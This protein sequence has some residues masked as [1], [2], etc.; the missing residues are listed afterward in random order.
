MRQVLK[1]QRV[2]FTTP[3]LSCSWSHSANHYGVICTGVIPALP[4][5]TAT[6]SPTPA[7]DGI[8]LAGDTSARIYKG[9]RIYTF[10]RG[11]GNCPAPPDEP[12][13]PAGSKLSAGTITCAVTQDD[14]ACID[15]IMNQGF[16]LSPAGSWSF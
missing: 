3:T 15:P 6:S 9:A 1:S 13:L 2:E 16:V 8:E 11:A 5:T 12:R 4:D 14:V 7:C 10:V